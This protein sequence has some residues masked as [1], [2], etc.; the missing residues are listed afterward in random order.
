VGRQRGG[1]RIPW[2]LLIALQ[3]V[4]RSGTNLTSTTYCPRD[5]PLEATV[6]GSLHHTTGLEA[7]KRVLY[8]HFLDHKVSA[9]YF[10]NMARPASPD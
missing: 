8:E 3:L 1:R 5:D 6:E 2:T 4:T 9:A 10:L 7:N